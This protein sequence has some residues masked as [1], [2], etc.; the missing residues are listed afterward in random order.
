MKKAKIFGAIKKFRP[1]LIADL[2]AQAGVRYSLEN[3]ASYVN[4]NIIGTFNILEAVRK[5]WG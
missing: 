4:S 1:E 2:G 5:V 3:P